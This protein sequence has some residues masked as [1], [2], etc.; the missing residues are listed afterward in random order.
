[1]VSQL[2]AMMAMNTHSRSNFRYHGASCSPIAGMYVE[3]MKNV[4]AI[5]HSSQKMLISPENC[6][7]LASRTSAMMFAV[8]SLRYR[9]VSTMKYTSSSRPPVTSH[10]MAMFC[11]HHMNGVPFWN[12]RN[13]GGSPSGDSRPPQLATIAM[14]NSTV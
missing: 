9:Y 10:S 5:T 1:M 12:R 11:I 14:K 8:G 2:K 13:N 6:I 4:L 3:L 7:F